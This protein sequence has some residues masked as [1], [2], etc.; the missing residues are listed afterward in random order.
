MARVASSIAA[1]ALRTAA[2]AENWPSII[3]SRTSEAS[4]ESIPE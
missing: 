1:R 4:Q 3:P 2:T